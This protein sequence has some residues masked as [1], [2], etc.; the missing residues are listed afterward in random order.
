MNQIGIGC[1]IEV[2]RM[3]DGQFGEVILEEAESILDEQVRCVGKLCQL[4]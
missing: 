3:N 4:F 2:R 1:S